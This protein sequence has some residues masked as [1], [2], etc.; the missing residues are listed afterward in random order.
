[1]RSTDLRIVITSPNGDVYRGVVDTKN[2]SG[3]LCLFDKDGQ[4]V[5]RNVPASNKTVV[6][7]RML[8]EILESESEDILAIAR[9]PKPGF[10][11]KGNNVVYAQRWFK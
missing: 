3:T 11:K 5:F 7:T 2:D 8:L 9:K 1:M 6:A 10:G 4:D